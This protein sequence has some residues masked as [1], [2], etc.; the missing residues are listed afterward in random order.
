MP[1]SNVELLHSY[2]MVGGEVAVPV[3]EWTAEDGATRIEAVFTAGNAD[4][5]ER[6]E[7]HSKKKFLEMILHDST[8][9]TY[10]EFE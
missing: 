3:R 6:T 10:R 7:Q 1:I 4:H 2:T 9:E 8:V 5:T